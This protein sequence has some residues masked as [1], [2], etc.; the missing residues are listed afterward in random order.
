MRFKPGDYFDQNKF[1]LIEKLGE[2]AYGIVWLAIMQANDMHVVVKMRK[3][4]KFNVDSN[5]GF[6]I[7]GRALGRLKHPNIIRIHGTFMAVENVMYHILDYGGGYTMSDC[8]EGK[9]NKFNQLSIVEKSQHFQ[10]LSSAIAAVHSAKI[11]HRDIKPSN[12]LWDGSRFYLC[13]FGSSFIDGLAGVSLD[14]YFAGGTSPA[15]E[16]VNGSGITVEQTDVF[17]LGAVFYQ[18]LTGNFLYGTNNVFKIKRAISDNRSNIHHGWTNEPSLLKAIIFKMLSP[19]IENRYSSGQELKTEFAAF[20]QGKRVSA[21]AETKS[22]ITA[23][24]IK[25]N[26]WPS[27]V[28]TCLTILFSLSFYLYVQDGQHR[29]QTKELLMAHSELLQDNDRFPG[30]AKQIITSKELMGFIDVVSSGDEVDDALRVS[31]LTGVSKQLI[32]EGSF[33]E[34]YAAVNSAL[35]IQSNDE[36]IILKAWCLRELAG[37]GGG[38][39][40]HQQAK[41]ILQ[42][43][44]NNRIFPTGDFNYDF[45]TLLAQNRLAT[46]VIRSKDKEDDQE[47]LSLLLEVNEKLA[48]IEMDNSYRWFTAINSMNLGSVYHDLGDLYSSL[49][50]YEESER[51][52]FE[53][54][55][56][57]HPELLFAYI[58]QAQALGELDEHEKALEKYEKAY[59]FV[60]FS[61]SD[62]SNIYFT[63]ALEYLAFMSSTD[64]IAHQTEI[65]KVA[66]EFCRKINELPADRVLPDDVVEAVKNYC[67][68]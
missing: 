47:A 33:F 17:N 34:A 39:N 11:V 35:E 66:D 32:S 45:A 2:G 57:T 5:Y 6:E 36:L 15:P 67:E 16:Q 53:A 1:R 60:R 4:Q 27:L 64:G 3:A 30:V 41:A 65:K 22:Q 10:S 19:K 68:S 46:I 52:F 23:R 44:L 55:L 31:L 62:K 38:E 42:E 56:D 21:K 18:W 14:N 8:F 58:G 54:G 25:H 29:N 24:W 40:N 9:C 7:E 63:T 12:I 50:H 13:D 43:L 59:Q 28:I 26:P 37:Y 48:T 20:L 51:L 49:Y 61:S